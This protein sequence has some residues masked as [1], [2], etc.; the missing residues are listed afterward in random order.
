MIAD[1]VKIQRLEK[2]LRDN[3]DALKRFN[4]KLVELMSDQWAADHQFIP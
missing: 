4:E 1:T 3:K 2:S